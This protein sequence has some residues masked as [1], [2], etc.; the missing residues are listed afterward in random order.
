[1]R[2]RLALTGLALL[3][4]LAPATAPA[5]E[6]ASEPPTAARVPVQLKLVE[7]SLAEHSSAFRGRMNR[8]P[9]SAR[10]GMR[11]TLL[12]RTGAGFEAVEAPGLERWRRSKA[13][14]GT[15]SYRQ[16]VRNLALNA[17]YRM[18]VDFRWWSASGRVVRRAGRLSP[19]CR[20]YAALPNLRA[21]V[22]G[23]AGTKVAGV[24]RYAL[25]LTNA[26]SAAATEAAVRLTVDGNV[27]DTRTLPA[28]APGE[29]RTLTFRGP[30]CAQSVGARADPD[31]LIVETSEVDNAQQVACAD[32]QRR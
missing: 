20:Q 11:F 26:G 24:V 30:D 28:L 18:R 25:Q 31:A 22:L 14:V 32:L 21:R 3:G 1:M 13:G 27:V 2:L 5:V 12:E 4:A 9:G 10:M 7:C 29:Q 23:A 15:F 6:T 17:A 19:V 8:L 16:G